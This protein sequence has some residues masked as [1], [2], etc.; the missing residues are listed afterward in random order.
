[1]RRLRAAKHGGAMGAITSGWLGYLSLLWVVLAALWLA[2][3]VY[4]TTLTIHEED[5]LL[6]SKGEAK[7]VE[8]QHIL[9]EKLNRLSTPLWASGTL[10]GVL[11]LLIFGIWLWRAINYVQ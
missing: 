11:L 9:V 3:L 1:V 8:E 5:T 2:L 7:A 10:A 6:L 4:R